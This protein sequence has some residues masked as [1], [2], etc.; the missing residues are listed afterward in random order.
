VN[1]RSFP[2]LT[3]EFRKADAN[4]TSTVFILSSLAMKV[5]DTDS[6]VPPQTVFFAPSHGAC[7]LAGGARSGGG[8]NETI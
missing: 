6:R 2:D 5:I 1:V 7:R 8:R 3:Q 4:L